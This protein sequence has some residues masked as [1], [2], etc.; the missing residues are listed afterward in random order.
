MVALLLTML[1]AAPL[2]AVTLTAPVAAPVSPRVAQGG[3]RARLDLGG[4]LAAS[5][6]V[7]PSRSRIDAALDNAKGSLRGH[8][9]FDGNALLLATPVVG[10]WVLAGQQRSLD[11]G[12][13]AL[14]VT[15]GV[16]QL[17][18]LSLG[19]LWLASDDDGPKAEGP[20]LTVSPIAGGRLGLS[21]K[22]TGF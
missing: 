13:R 11:G 22:L 12:D 20:V 1:S 4:L 5:W 6:Y 9:I 19:A 7:A 16:L 14:L 10:P 15:S 8:A 17:V 21:V 18:G 2:A 3:L